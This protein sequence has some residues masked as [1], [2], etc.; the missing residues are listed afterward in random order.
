MKNQESCTSRGCDFKVKSE[1]FKG[2]HGFPLW[3][4]GEGWGM[5]RPWRNRWQKMK[6]RLVALGGS[7]AVRDLSQEPTLSDLARRL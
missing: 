2:K 4:D 7:G 1:K 6:G 3:A 5:L